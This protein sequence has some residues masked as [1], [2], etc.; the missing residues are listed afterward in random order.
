MHIRDVLCYPLGVQ[1]QGYI[2]LLYLLWFKPNFSAILQIAMQPC[3]PKNIMLKYCYFLDPLH[4][5]AIFPWV[6][7]TQYCGQVSHQHLY[8]AHLD[9]IGN[10]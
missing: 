6:A 1:T 8:T 5:K 2:T 4:W 3:V 9:M 10:Q 7:F